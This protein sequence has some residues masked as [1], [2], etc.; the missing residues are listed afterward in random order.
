MRKTVEKTIGTAEKPNSPDL[1]K[2]KE[3]DVAAWTRVLQH[4]GGRVRV[5]Q[6]EGEA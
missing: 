3:Y 4:L 2:P 5:E 1:V 6:E